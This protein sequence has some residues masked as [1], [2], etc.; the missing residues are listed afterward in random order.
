MRRFVAGMVLI[1]LALVVP[2]ARGQTP[3]GAWW[4]PEKDERRYPQGYGELRVVESAGEVVLKFTTEDPGRT[5]YY[6]KDGDCS[7]YPSAEDPANET[8]V[9]PDECGRPYA[10][11][12]EDYGAVRGEWT[13]TE[14]GSRTI[15]IPIVDD[16][17]DETDGEAFTII[18]VHQTDFWPTAVLYNAFIHIGDDDP[19]DDSDGG[20]SSSSSDANAIPGSA[21][22]DALVGRAATVSAIPAP[23]AGGE[24][25]NVAL[26]AGSGSELASDEL[27]P[28]AGFELTS[29]QSPE[30]PSARGDG[31]GGSTSWL[32]L[33][34]GGA[35]LSVGAIVLA[36]RRLRWSPTRV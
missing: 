25:P 35:A 7:G 29:D 1:L 14:A 21:A 27:Q 33:G 23:V 4:S 12:G 10:R 20:P 13:F 26:Q 18:A 8:P 9:S 11:A 19:R 22:G 34:L 36:R 24:D 15:R 30:P 3:K 6:T 28:G 17:L 31:G 5:E 16:D 2:P 32:P